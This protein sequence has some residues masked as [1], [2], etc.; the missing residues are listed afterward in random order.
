MKLNVGTPDR[1]ARLLAAVIISA[2]CLARAMNGTILVTLEASAV[3][4]VISGLISWC[5]VYAAAGIS[6]VRKRS[7]YWYMMNNKDAQP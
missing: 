7:H 3:V 2:V 5:P 6:T 1:V 4:L